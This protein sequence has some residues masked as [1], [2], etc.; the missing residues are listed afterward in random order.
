VVD[1]IYR[2]G[3][4]PP[5]LVVPGVTGAFSMLEDIAQL[6]APL[7]MKNGR[8]NTAGTHSKCIT[9][10]NIFHNQQVRTTIQ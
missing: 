2:T 7:I 5:L 1:E 10:M 3:V 8:L 4:K 9:T 6:V